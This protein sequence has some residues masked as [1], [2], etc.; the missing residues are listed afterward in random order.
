MMDK[1]VCQC[2]SVRC[3]ITIYWKSKHYHFR[4]DSNGNTFRQPEALLFLGNI[5][6]E[7]AK[8]KAQGIPFNPDTYTDAAMRERKFEYQYQLYLS[9]KRKELEDDGLSP[10]HYHH[11]EGYYRSQYTHFVDKDVKEIDLALLT[12]FKDTLQGRKK[13]KRNALN[14]LHAFFSWMKGRGMIDNAP[15]FPI[16]KG[17][18]AQRRMVLRPGEQQGPKRNS[19]R[20]TVM[21]FSS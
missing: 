14:S 20:S 19:P 17:N 1:E 3:H 10:E 8:C 9:E 4:R 11:L 5:N 2:G 7:I 13:T 6:Q 16:I 18:D 12:K 15:Q 21:L